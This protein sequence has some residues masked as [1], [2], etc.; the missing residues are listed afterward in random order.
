LAYKYTWGEDRVYYHDEAGK[1]CQVPAGYTNVIQP[2]PY[3]VINAGRS[4]FRV[5]DLLE[6]CCLMDKISG[7]PCSLQGKKGGVKCVK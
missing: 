2:D 1:L 5:V 7:A 3:V 6:L 4:A